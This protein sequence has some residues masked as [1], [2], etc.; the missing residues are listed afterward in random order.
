MVLSPGA[1]PDLELGEPYSPVRFLSATPISAN[2]A[3]WARLKGVDAL[4]EAWR[5]D[6][7]DVTDPQRV[8]A[9]PS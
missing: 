2:E 7:V 5:Q 9:Q 3:A 1:I 6:G 4:R 8:A